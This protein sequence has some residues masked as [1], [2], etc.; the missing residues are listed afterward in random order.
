MV[1]LAWGVAAHAAELTVAGITFSDAAGGFVLESASG[2]GRLDDPFV[3]V[4]RITG[5]GEAALTVT[6]LTPAFGNRVGTAHLTGFAL[7]KVVRN[8]TREAWRDFPVE[9][10]ERRG[11][12]SPYGDGL[13]FAQGPVSDGPVANR[14]VRSDRFAAAQVLDE[15]RDVVLFQDGMVAPGEAVTVRVIIT[16]NTPAPR[17]YVVQRR[18]QPTA[19][20]APR[21][22][23]SSFRRAAR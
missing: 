11:D 7:V 3:V 2:S 22:G 21:R 23:S 10:Q 20:L 1:L 9:L 15:P 12:Q 17:F 19:E 13:S 8:A 6:G 16:D 14:S 5:Q 4:E 18:T